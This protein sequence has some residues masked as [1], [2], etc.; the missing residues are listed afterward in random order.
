MEDERQDLQW[1]VE[2]LRNHMVIAVAD[3]SYGFNVVPNIR[4]AGILLCCTKSHWVITPKFFDPLLM[5]SSYR[6]IARAGGS[7]HP[8]GALSLL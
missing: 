5:G 2:G 3:G 4:S 6:G 8:S 7:S 1:P